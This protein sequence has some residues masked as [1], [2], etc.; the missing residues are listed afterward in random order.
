MQAKIVIVKSTADLFDFEMVFAEKDGK[1]DQP[2]QLDQTKKK[3][4][5]MPALLQ[6]QRGA[7]KCYEWTILMQALVCR[8]EPVELLQITAV[9]TTA[10]HLIEGTGKG[11]MSFARTKKKKEEMPALLQGQRG[12]SKCY[13]QL[14]QEYSKFDRILHDIFAS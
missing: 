3:K 7:S 1:S 8:Y 5:G 14:K 9:G 13:F 11:L 6:G 4:E 12:G 10:K 2:Q